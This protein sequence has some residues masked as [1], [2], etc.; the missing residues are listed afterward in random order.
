MFTD[1]FIWF[2]AFGSFWCWSLAFAELNNLSPFNWKLNLSLFHELCDVF[3]GNMQ[4]N[5][6]SLSCQPFVKFWNNCFVVV[7]LQIF[8][9][10][11]TEWLLSCK[12]EAAVVTETNADQLTSLSFAIVSFINWPG[13]SYY[14]PLKSRKTLFLPLFF[15]SVYLLSMNI[16]L[17]KK[18]TSGGF[19]FFVFSYRNL[20]FEENWK[21]AL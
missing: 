14:K 5:T 19:L 17:W 15:S 13:Y 4:W 16:R 6:W 9:K 12:T 7:Q 11:E 20:I 1:Q 3:A 10:L 2:L 18:G 8:R 21:S